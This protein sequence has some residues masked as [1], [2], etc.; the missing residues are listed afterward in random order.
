M[1]LCLCDTTGEKDIHI[2][3]TLVHQGLA[4]FRQD[5]AITPTSIPPEVM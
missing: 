5:D 3:D 2:N 4:E 1:S